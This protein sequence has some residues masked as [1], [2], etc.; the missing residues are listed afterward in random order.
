MGLNMSPHLLVSNLIF[1]HLY[2]DVVGEIL[3][4][5]REYRPADREKSILQISMSRSSLEHVHS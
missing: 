2:F 5:M 3:I 4:L 1:V